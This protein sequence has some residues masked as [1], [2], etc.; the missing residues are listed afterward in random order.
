MLGAELAGLMGCSLLASQ[1]TILLFVVMHSHSLSLVPA[2]RDKENYLPGKM[3]LLP[4]TCM[5]LF[6]P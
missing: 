5:P 6:E 1:P 2:T 3:L 4:R